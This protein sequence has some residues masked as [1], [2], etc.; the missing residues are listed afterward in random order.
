MNIPCIPTIPLNYR[1]TSLIKNPRTPSFILFFQRILTAHGY[2]PST[3]KKLNRK[4]LID[5]WFVYLKEINFC[6]V[7]FSEDLILRMRILAFFA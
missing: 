1:L 3:V 2:H 5:I 4:C 7:N 6:E